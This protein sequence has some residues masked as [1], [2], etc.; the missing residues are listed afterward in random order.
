MVALAVPPESVCKPLTW[1]EVKKMQE[2]GWVSFGAHTMHHPILACL[3]D[4]QEVQREVSDCRA[5]LEEHLGQPVRAFAYPV[6]KP[7]H[8]GQQ[9]LHSVRAAGYAWALTTL[10]GTN[11]RQ[12]DLHQ[13]RRVSSVVNRHWLVIAAET[14]GAWYFFSPLWK[15]K[16]A[17][18]LR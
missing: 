7:E 9:G 1:A 14:S 8:F 6:G 5:V 13:L 4:P 3:R 15:K 11:T 10:R 16:S 2:S 12:S 18:S 17:A